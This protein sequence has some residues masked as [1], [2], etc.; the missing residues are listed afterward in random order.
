MPR[1]HLEANRMFQRALAQIVRFPGDSLRQAFVTCRYAQQQMEVG[2]FFSLNQPV[3][4]TL[5]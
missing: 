5:D 3:L 1:I 4:A 2:S